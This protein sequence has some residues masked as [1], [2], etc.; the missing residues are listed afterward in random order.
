MDNSKKISAMLKEKSRELRKIIL[1]AIYTAGKGHIGGAY[2]CI[3]IIVGIYYGEILNYDVRDPEWDSRDYFLMSKGHAG[4]AQY[5]AL[6]DIGYIKK[7]ELGKLNN[8]GSLGEHPS[9]NTCGIEFISGSLGHGLSIAGGIALSAKMDREP[10]QVYVLLG[11]GECYEGST[12]EAAMFIAHHK[13]N[14]V[15]AIIDRNRLITSGDTEDINRLEPFVDKW[16]S[17]GWH[18]E[19]IDGHDFEQIIEVMNRFKDKKTTKPFV[20]IAN[21]LKGK[22]VSFM[23]GQSKW[24]HG[25]INEDTFVRAMEEL[26]R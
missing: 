14:N 21:T 19:E 3:D 25:S 1:E 11:D 16:L 17:F 2:S 10:N 8:K 13:L 9:N 26:C 5:A 7:T 12:W 20:I 18:V 6:A 4:I 24:H 22:G 15:C 23:E